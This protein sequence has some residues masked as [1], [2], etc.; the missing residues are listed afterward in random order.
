MGDIIAHDFIT[1]IIDGESREI[2]EVYP[3]IETFVTATPENPLNADLLISGYEDF[4]SSAQYTTMASPNNLTRASRN[5]RNL[6]PTKQVA[7]L[8]SVSLSKRLEDIM[9]DRESKL[10]EKIELEDLLTI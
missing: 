5:Y 8:L 6:T 4:L 1:S 7:H 10:A 3:S 9:L 2:K